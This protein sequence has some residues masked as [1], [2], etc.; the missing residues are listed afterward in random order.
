VVRIFDCL[1]V[2]RAKRV[3]IINTSL[4]IYTFLS[5]SLN[6]YEIP[7]HASLGG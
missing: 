2:E 4:R 5:I 6:E 1:G 3:C 7:I